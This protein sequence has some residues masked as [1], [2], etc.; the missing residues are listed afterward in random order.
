AAVVPSG[1]ARGGRGGRSA[2]GRGPFL[3]ACVVVPDDTARASQSAAAIPHEQ[4]ASCRSALEGRTAKEAADILRRS[5]AVRN[6]GPE[7]QVIVRRI[8]GVAQAVEAEEPAF[9]GDHRAVRMQRSEMRAAA[10]VRG[11]ILRGGQV[12]AAGEGDV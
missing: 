8:G 3:A 6:E 12:G 4:D 11:P 5:R 7:V 2:N 1:R 9:S 10:V